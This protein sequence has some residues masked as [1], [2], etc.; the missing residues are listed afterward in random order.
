MLNRVALG[1]RVQMYRESK[2]LT[3]NKV[4][5]ACGVTA[6]HMSQIESSNK[7]PSLPIFLTLCSVLG[8]T[9][10]VLLQE[11]LKDIHR[12]DGTDQILYSLKSLKSEY[13]DLVVKMIQ[14]FIEKQ[15]ENLSD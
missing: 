13:Y 6:A 5:E 4:A 14:V 7:L 12:D 10:D 11:S 9:A 2:G 3:L 1:K 15:N 8:V